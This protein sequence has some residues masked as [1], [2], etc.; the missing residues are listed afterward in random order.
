MIITGKEVVFFLPSKPDDA[1]N[2]DIKNAPLWD[3]LQTLSESRKVQIDGG[4]PSRLQ[5]LRR[6]LMAGDDVSVCVHNAPFQSVANELSSLSGLPL[7]VTSGDVKTLLTLTVKGSTLKEIVAQMSAQ[8]DVQ[9][10]TK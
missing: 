6:T 1:I 8:T 2:L 10:A 4:N 5:I 9:I 3:V 7:R